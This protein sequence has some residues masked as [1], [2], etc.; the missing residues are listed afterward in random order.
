MQVDSP[1]EDLRFEGGF[2]FRRISANNTRC[3]IAPGKPGG[4]SASFGHAKYSRG[5]IRPC[6]GCKAV[7][8]WISLDLVAWWPSG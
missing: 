4:G 5:V 2:T 8:A 1:V 7:N 3:Y 6:R